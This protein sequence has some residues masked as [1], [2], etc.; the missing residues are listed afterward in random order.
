MARKK[1]VENTRFYSFLEDLAQLPDS[2][3]T[4]PCYFKEFRFIDVFLTVR[5]SNNPLNF[6]FFI[7]KKEKTVRNSFASV[8]LCLQF[9]CTPE[10]FNLL[11]F[12]ST[13]LKLS[14]F[15][16]ILKEN[17]PEFKSCYNDLIDNDHVAGF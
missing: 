11:L 17:C 10:V 15:I 5:R 13:I 4:E 6:V 9:D 14:D 8:F 2:C 1:Y 7:Y 16:P 12:D 3:T